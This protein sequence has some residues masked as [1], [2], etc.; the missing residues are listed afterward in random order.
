MKRALV[1]YLV[2]GLFLSSFITFSAPRSQAQT[3]G[4]VSAVLQRMESNYK[5]LKNMKSGIRMLK[6]NAQTRETEDYAGYLHYVP[7]KGRSGSV[8]LDWYQP[9]KETLAVKDGD[10]TLYRE[11]LKIAY[12]GKTA[13][14]EAG[15]S[16][17]ALNFLSMSGAQLK[18]S[19]NAQVVGNEDLGGGLVAT[20]LYL[21]PKGK[22]N[23]NSAEIWVDGNGMPVQ[24]KINEKNNDFTAIRVYQ[25][26]R[27]ARFDDKIFKL[28][29][30]KDVKTVKA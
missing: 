6:Y 30:P 28:D 26:E 15:K 19:F 3:Q 14:A 27:N 4:L 11:R 10:Y 2:I 5:T 13:Q 7:G 29:L 24:V 23:Y 21:T 9:Y 18:A 8:R 17:G 20:K 1:S 16:N 25:I 12:K 22:A